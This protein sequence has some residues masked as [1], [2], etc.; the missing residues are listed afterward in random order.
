MQI[1]A[2][3]VW[4]SH[5]L[6]LNERGYVAS[7]SCARGMFCYVIVFIT[8][9]VTKLI[10]TRAHIRNHAVMCIHSDKSQDVRKLLL[11]GLWNKYTT[12]DNATLPMLPLKNTHDK[13][14]YYSKL[15]I[16]KVL[17]AQFTRTFAARSLALQ[18]KLRQC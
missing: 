9:Y 12:P 8:Y 17:I 15:L 16:S 5:T 18:A 2:G 1:K 3:V 13:G 10:K 11:L 7:L 6:L 14:S 4:Y